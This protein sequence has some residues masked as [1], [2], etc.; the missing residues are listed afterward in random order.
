VLQEKHG[1]NGRKTDHEE[2]VQGVDAVATRFSNMAN[3]T[4]SRRENAIDVLYGRQ[5]EK[6]LVGVAPAH[7]M[8]VSR[9]TGGQ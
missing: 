3:A 2:D 4:R 5:S 9:W 7:A 8:H 6:R 1:L